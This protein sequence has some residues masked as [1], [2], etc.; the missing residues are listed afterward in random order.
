MAAEQSSYN[1]NCSKGRQCSNKELAGLGAGVIVLWLILFIAYSAVRLFTA[2]LLIGVGLF[3]ILGI[4]YACAYFLTPKKELTPQQSIYIQSC[5]AG[6]CFVL[7]LLNFL[8]APSYRADGPPYAPVVAWCD[9]IACVFMILSVVTSVLLS[10]VPWQTLEGRYECPV[11]EAEW[12]AC[13]IAL[14][15]PG[16]WTVI[17]DAMY[18][19]YGGHPGAVGLFVVD[20]LWSFIS[21]IGIGWAIYA[22]MPVRDEIDF[23]VTV[24]GD[25]HAHTHESEHA[26]EQDST[27]EAASASSQESASLLTP[28]L[29][30]AAMALRASDAPQTSSNV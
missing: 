30:A 6:L 3:I 22:H 28:S 23:H 21:Y 14:F 5:I 11:L 16:V 25:K 7:S 29:A 17:G 15:V 9:L 27:Q 26:H 12:V 24:E 18:I 1:C 2:A 19:V 4:G 13:V 10:S 8:C 20:S